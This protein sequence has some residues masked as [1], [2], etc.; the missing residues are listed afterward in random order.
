MKAEKGRVNMRTLVIDRFE[1]KYAVC[2]D[3][4]QRLFTIAVEKLPPDAGEGSVLLISEEGKLL[5]DAG[6]T[7]RRRKRIAEKQRGIFEK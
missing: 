2:E 7:A 5:L 1:G 3:E 6:E 4:K